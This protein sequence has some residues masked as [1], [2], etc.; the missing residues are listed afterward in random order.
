VRGEQPAGAARRS[1]TGEPPQ[2]HDDG[3]RDVAGIVRGEPVVVEELREE[4]AVAEGVAATVGGGANGEKGDSTP[5][6]GARDGGGL[7]VLHVRRRRLPRFEGRDGRPGDR[8]RRQLAS[9][10]LVA[11][12]RARKGVPP[13]GIAADGV[14]T[15]DDR[16]IEEQADD[17]GIGRL[18]RDRGAPLERFRK[19]R[20]GAPGQGEEGG[21]GVEYPLAI[22]L[23]H[24]RGE[25]DVADVM[26]GSRRAAHD[27]AGDLAVREEIVR[28]VRGVHEPDAREAEEHAHPAEP[29]H[30]EGSSSDLDG[31]LDLRR[32]HDRGQL[33]GKGRDHGDVGRRRVLR[34]RGRTESP[35]SATPGVRDGW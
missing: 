8:R 20:R 34:R 27:E 22:A 30:V 31:R 5:R 17:G 19:R 16:G 1:V 24:L 3:A 21:V 6:G 35:P 12:R 28:P 32:G 4:A 33:G 15:E 23:H 14:P 11:P 13:E 7:H 18:R 2:L 25:H 10:D 29:A 26:A 9:D